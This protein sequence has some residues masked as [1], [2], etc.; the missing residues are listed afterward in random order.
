MIKFEKLKLQQ[1]WIYFFMPR[2][3]DRHIKVDLL[4]NMCLIFCKK[5]EQL[6]LII[7]VGDENLYTMYSHVRCT[8]QAT[9][10]PSHQHTY[11]IEILLC[12]IYCCYLA[13]HYQTKRVDD[14]WDKILGSL[15]RRLWRG[16]EHERNLHCIRICFRHRIWAATLSD[17][18]AYLYYNANCLS[19]FNDILV[20]STIYEHWECR[21][22]HYCDVIMCAMASQITS[23]TV[24]YSTVYSGPA[25]R[26]HQSSASLAVLRGIHRSP[27]NFPSQ[28][29]SYAEM[30]PFDDVIMP[31]WNTKAFIVHRQ[32]YG[33][34]WHSSGE[35][36]DNYL[37][38]PVLLYYCDFNI[39]N[40]NSGSY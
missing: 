26:K 8:F 6:N 14:P 18:T 38:Y 16:N 30:F 37:I 23:L 35:D 21:S 36:V 22:S 32:N 15:W 5:D 1:H 31:Q 19:N 27:V 33:Y 40:V 34:W 12:V 17:G 25:Q 2:C 28:M 20:F 7:L 24:V 11:L 39:R 4:S 9:Y 3:K 29:A 10:M 13:L